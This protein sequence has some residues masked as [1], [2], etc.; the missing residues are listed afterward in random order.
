[1]YLDAVH[2]GGR[3]TRREGDGS[4]DGDRERIAFGIDEYTTPLTSRTLSRGIHHARCH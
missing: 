1:M 2:N 4:E 3:P